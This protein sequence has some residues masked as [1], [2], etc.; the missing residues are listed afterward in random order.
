MMRTPYETAFGTGWVAFDA[1]GIT[2]ITLPGLAAPEGAV[3]DAV[4]ESVAATV[5]HLEAYFSAGSTGWDLDAERLADAAGTTEFTRA[6][7]RVVASIPA[8]STMTYGEVAAAAGRPGAARAVGAAMARNP[9]APIIPCHRVL[10]GNGGLGGYGGGLPMKE[11]LL[12]MEGAMLIDG[13]AR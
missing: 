4:P 2:Q 10:A 7:Y 1:V 3:T 13:G 9:F 8:G 5:E 12:A 6:V 11:A